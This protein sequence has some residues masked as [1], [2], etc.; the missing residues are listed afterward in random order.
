MPMFF[1]E[2]E[3]PKYPI[4]MYKYEKIPEAILK[5]YTVIIS[6]GSCLGKSIVAD[7]FSGSYR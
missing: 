5:D 4:S 2:R 3:T 7:I 1:Y 6:G